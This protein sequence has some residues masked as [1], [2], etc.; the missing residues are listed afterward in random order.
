MQ[1]KLDVPNTTADIP[2]AIE[3]AL[4]KRAEFLEKR[5]QSKEAPPVKVPVAS[6]SKDVPPTDAAVEAETNG[7]DD[8]DANGAEDAEAGA[9]DMNDA[10]AE[11]SAGPERSSK[12]VGLTVE[13]DELTTSVSIKLDVADGE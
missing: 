6:S 11:I 4:A 10:T 2:A 13:A 3:A 8:A 12:S 1:L 9:V 5:K 7:I